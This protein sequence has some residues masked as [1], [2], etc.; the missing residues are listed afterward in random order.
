MTSFDFSPL[1]RTSVGFDRLASMLNAANRL[2]QVGGYPPYNI[3]TRAENQYRITMAVA[4]FDESE[5]NITSENNQLTVSGQKQD[6]DSDSGEFLYRGI[7]KRSFERRLNLA[8]PV[9]VTAAAQRPAV[10]RPRAGTAGSHEASPDSHRQRQVAARRR[11]QRQGHDQQ[12]RLR[13]LSPRGRVESGHEA[14]PSRGAARRPFF[15]PDPAVD[16]RVS[17]FWR[18][19]GTLLVRLPA[20]PFI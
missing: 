10:H 1:F 4:G 12:S 17:G 13:P 7:A 18:A 9:K 8:D 16:W 14:L 6:G 3:E 20:G 2:E 19:A 11:G 5:L 15:A